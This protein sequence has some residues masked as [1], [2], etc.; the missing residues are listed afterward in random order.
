MPPTAATGRVVRV[1]AVG[2]AAAA[3]WVLVAPERFA[4]EGAA[5]AAPVPAPATAATATAPTPATA[6]PGPAP[7][8]APGAAPGPP[9]EPGGASGPRLVEVRGGW[10]DG[11]DL[12]T[13]VALAVLVAG[14][15]AAGDAAGDAAGAGPVAV[16]AVEQP[17][18]GA[19]VVTLLVGPADAAPDGDGAIRTRRLAVPVRLGPEGVR[20]AGTPWW[21]PGPRLD[22]AVPAGRPLA[23]PVLREAA[24]AALAAAGSPLAGTPF[25]LEAT[26]GWPFL[27]RP[28][29]DGRPDAGADGEEGGRPAV[30]LRWHL[31]RFVV[32]GLPLQPAAGTE[33]GTGVP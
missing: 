27:V 29:D 16:E 11:E 1:V 20:V 24:D 7:G 6:A 19:A 32:A 21:L 5:P 13:A 15:H 33:Q 12:G 23:D 30:W 4:P 3:A 10:R 25:E 18:P 9:A 14:T 22:A 28:G 31:D 2:L 8:T 17:G 26:D